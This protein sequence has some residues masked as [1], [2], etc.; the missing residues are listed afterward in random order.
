MIILAQE[1]FSFQH[2]LDKTIQ[3]SLLIPAAFGLALF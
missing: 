1:I 3:D 2:K